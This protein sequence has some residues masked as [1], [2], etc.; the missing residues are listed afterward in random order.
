MSRAR[1]VT[2]TEIEFAALVE[3]SALYEAE[4]D[5]DESTAETRADN[6]A[7]TRLIAKWHAAGR[8]AA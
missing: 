4:Y 6:R 5:G 3:A 1:K 2:M 8:R 7:L